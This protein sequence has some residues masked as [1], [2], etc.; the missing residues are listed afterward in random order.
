MITFDRFPNGRRHIVTMSYDD[1]RDF[2]RR[3][4]AL[5]N[6][7]GI[8]GTFHLNSGKFGL[9]GYITRE[10]VAQLYAGHEVS[11]HTAHHPRLEQMPAACAAKDIMDDRKTL[12]SLCGYPVRGMSYP[13]G[14]YNDSVLNMLPSCGIVYSRTVHATN[15]F[16]LPSNFFEWHPTCHHRDALELAKPFLESLTMPWRVCLFYIWGH[17]YEFDND[18]N[19]DYMEEV[20]RM[21]GGREDIWYATNIEIYDYITTQRR[22]QFS[23]DCK[24]VI[25]PSVQT[26]W[27]NVDGEAVEIPG[28]ATVRL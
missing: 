28:G 6:Q 5:F 3:L 15:G 1:G 14:T 24:T 23:A 11:A 25:N 7:Y 22:L 2:D 26:V 19:W 18:N 13:Y 27:I 20:C 4:V 16:Q 17:S 9:D 8:R 21:L 12:E 10:E